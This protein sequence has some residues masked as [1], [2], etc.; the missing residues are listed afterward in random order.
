MD[1]IRTVRSVYVYLYFAKCKA[2]R[3]CRKHA[4]HLDRHVN[5]HAQVVLI[6]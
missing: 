5:I 3:V 1:D 6:T 2:N 4:F